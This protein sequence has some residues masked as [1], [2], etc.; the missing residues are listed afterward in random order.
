M[1][2]AVCIILNLLVVQ[3]TCLLGEP[4]MVHYARGCLLGCRVMEW[5][6]ISLVVDSVVVLAK[7]LSLSGLNSFFIMPSGCMEVQQE[8]IFSGCFIHTILK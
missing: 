5:L 1:F 6:P 2:F 3:L 4:P 8:E 7:K